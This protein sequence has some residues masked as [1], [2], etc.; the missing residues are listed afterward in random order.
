MAGCCCC[1]YYH[2]YYHIQKGPCRPT[3]IRTETVEGGGEGAPH[4]PTPHS[5]ALMA[6]CYD[7]PP[8]PSYS[9][10]LSF[11]SHS[12]DHPPRASLT[13]PLQRCTSSSTQPAVPGC[14]W[15]VSAQP[16]YPLG[17]GSVRTLAR[18][19]LKEVPGTAGIGS[20]CLRKH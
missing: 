5:R 13:W 19:P 4:H 11:L 18:F 3:R 20:T 7:C 16:I 12:R 2:P 15:S 1:C 10:P 6:L 14:T 17:Q 8:V 9:W